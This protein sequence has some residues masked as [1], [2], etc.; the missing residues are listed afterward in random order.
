MALKDA[1]MNKMQIEMGVD[2]RGWAPDSGLHQ[3]SIQ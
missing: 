1:V 2:P 3:V